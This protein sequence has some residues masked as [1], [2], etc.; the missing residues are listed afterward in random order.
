MSRVE[1]VAVFRRSPSFQCLILHL[2]HVSSPRSSNPACGFPALGSRLRSCSRPRES[3]P[4][5]F[6]RSGRNRA[7]G[8]RQA[9]FFPGSA[10]SFRPSHR[11]GAPVP[12]HGRHAARGSL[13]FQTRRRPE[14]PH[15][16]RRTRAHSLRRHY[17][18][19]PV[20]RASTPPRRPK[21]A[22]LQ[23]LPKVFARPEAKSPRSRLIRSYN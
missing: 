12:P 18:T 15:R 4:A 21:L 17:R 11:R 13:R 14:F 1:G 2:D 23:S 7:A 3:A 8:T 19:S 20:P 6:R 22:L 9:H 10:S 5:A 16:N